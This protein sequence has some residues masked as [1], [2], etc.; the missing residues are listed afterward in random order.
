MIEIKIEDK[1]EKKINEVLSFRYEE[2]VKLI[3]MEI[4]NIGNDDIK[5][6]LTVETDCG[7]DYEDTYSYAEFNVLKKGMK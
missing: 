4:F 3:K 6:Y 5:F 2:N 7:I 1:L